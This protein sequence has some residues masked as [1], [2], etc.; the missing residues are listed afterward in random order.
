[1]YFGLNESG[2]AVWTLLSGGARE[3][4]HLYEGLL[5]A[6]PDADEAM[7]RTDVDRLIGELVRHGLLRERV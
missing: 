3:A 6:F 7:V 1:V 5:A 2:L 4:K